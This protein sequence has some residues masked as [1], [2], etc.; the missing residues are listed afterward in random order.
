M[1]GFAPFLSTSMRRIVAVLCVCTATACASAAGPD[2]SFDAAT[3]FSRY[4]TY[5]WSTTGALQDLGAESLVE[6]RAAIEQM[7]ADRGFRQ[8]ANSDFTVSFTASQLAYARPSRSRYTTRPSTA[9]AY[10]TPDQTGESV[11][12]LA[13][14]ITET[15][16]RR[17]LWRGSTSAVF[18]GAKAGDVAQRLVPRILV[19]FPP[20]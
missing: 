12:T 11:V 14:S 19:S 15:A 2:I 17:S 9:F 5:S 6:V 4:R 7:L 18:D 8:A 1:S 10:S 3:D 13:I 20:R 16:T